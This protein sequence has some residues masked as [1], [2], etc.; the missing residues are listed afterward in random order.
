MQA[1]M[2]PDALAPDDFGAPSRAHEGTLALPTMPR[3]SPLLATQEGQVWA[4][5]EGGLDEAGRR[6]LEGRIEASVPL[7]CQRCLGVYHHQVAGAFRV[8]IVATEEEGEAL[9]DELEPYVSGAAV[10]PLQV[11]EEEILLALPVVARHS[12]N[13][14]GAPEHG[15][16]VEREALSPF[17]SLQGRVRRQADD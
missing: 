16:G 2:L 13:D 9:P 1:L 17:A 15:A 8:V 6:V 10:R 7:T 14:C 12:G 3:L 4:R 11:I 5:L